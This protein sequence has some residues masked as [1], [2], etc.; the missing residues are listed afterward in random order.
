MPPG[1]G[2]GNPGPNNK[3]KAWLN[4]TYL[5]SVSESAQR[6]KFDI[7]ASFTDSMM[8][9]GG[10]FVLFHVRTGG[11]KVELYRLLLPPQAIGGSVA[12][13]NYR[14]VTQATVNLMLGRKFWL[15]LSFVDS[16]GATK[17]RG[18]IDYPE[19]NVH[20]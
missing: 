2:T 1:I 20:P 16:T 7:V 17:P 5:Q 11:E 6:L 3:W 10:S 18:H 13:T 14:F 15:E 12:A 19:A 8:P 9:N 4:V